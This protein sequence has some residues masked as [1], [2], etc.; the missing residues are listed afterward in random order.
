MESDVTDILLIAE[1]IKNII[2]T[3]HELRTMD[4][5]WEDTSSFSLKF[6][7]LVDNAMG[8][9]I[10]YQD[11]RLKGFRML[12][13]LVY[14]ADI[15]LKVE[16]ATVKTAIETIVCDTAGRIDVN[17]TMFKRLTTSCLSRNGISKFWLCYGITMALISLKCVHALTR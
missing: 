10:K 12:T 15:Y 16:D 3:D 14:A 9:E 11:E 1:D 17:W 4:W 6:Q 7:D 8:N 5:I 13:V 2:N